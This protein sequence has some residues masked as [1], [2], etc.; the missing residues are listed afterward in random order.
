MPVEPCSPKPQ[1]RL[2]GFPVDPCRSNAMS[3]L[4]LPV[5]L[6]LLASRRLSEVRD[7]DNSDWPTLDDL[8]G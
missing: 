1:C 6:S 7:S 3:H 4:H 2:S 8:V 5:L